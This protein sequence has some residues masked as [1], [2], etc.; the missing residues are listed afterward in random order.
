MLLLVA[1]GSISWLFRSDI[2]AAWYY[3]RAL[4]EGRTGVVS[5]GSQTYRVEVVST[6]SELARGLSGRSKLWHGFG[7]LFVMP[8]E[9]HVTF[10]M[11]DMRFPLDIVW[12]SQG[13]V[14]GVERNLPYPQAGTEPVL[15]G[16]PNVSYVLEV[17]EGDA[18]N[19]FS[20]DKAVLRLNE[21][22]ID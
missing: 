4:V 5:V 12:I 20:A 19:V 17:N 21:K 2:E 13:M 10:W 18:A 7:M 14:A 9:E 3:V 11:K 15:V 6:A 16:S 8:N 1:A 22:R